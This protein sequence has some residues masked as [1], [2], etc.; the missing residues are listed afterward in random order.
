MI[1]YSV[2]TPTVYTS[3]KD[4]G[5][6]LTMRYLCDVRKRR[7][8]EQ[9]IWENVLDEFAK[10][11]DIDFAYPTTRFYNNLGEGKPGTKPSGPN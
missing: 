4:S 7:T 1:F 3:V 5:V 2:L 11:S 10:H 9:L 6:M 8:T